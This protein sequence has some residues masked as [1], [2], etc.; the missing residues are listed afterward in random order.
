VWDATSVRP[1]LTLRG[2]S[3]AVYDVAFC[4]DGTRLAT[5]SADKTVRI[6]ALNIEDLMA[7]ARTCVT[8]SLTAEECRKELHVEQCPPAP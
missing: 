4:P 2:H 1:L 3:D 7:L 6:Y 5:A 8:R